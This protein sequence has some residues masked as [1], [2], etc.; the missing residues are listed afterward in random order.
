VQPVG[1]EVKHE[2]QD[3]DDVN[4]EIVNGDP[5]FAFGLAEEGDEEQPE[6]KLDAEEEKPVADQLIQVT[7]DRAVRNYFVLH[8][9]TS[10]Q[11]SMRHAF[12]DP[13]MEELQ[14]RV[15]LPLNNFAVDSCL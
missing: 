9:T 10:A 8:N 15:G 12:D 1:A 7:L 5:D 3:A 6:E 2:E 14:G 4:P 13:D 11:S